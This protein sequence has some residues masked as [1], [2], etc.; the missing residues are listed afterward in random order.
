MFHLN[1]AKETALHRAA[2]KGHLQMVKHLII[3][4][5]FDVKDKNKVC[6]QHSLTVG[7]CLLQWTE[8]DS[9]LLSKRLV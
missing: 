1:D 7:C 6:M 5:G 2:M 8:E 4:A 9:S 3:S